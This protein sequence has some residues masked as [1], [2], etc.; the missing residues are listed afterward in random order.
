[1]VRALSSTM[2]HQYA[3]CLNAAAFGRTCDTDARDSDI[4]VAVDAANASLDA[5]CSAASYNEIGFA[6]E[7][8]SIR[9]GLVAQVIASARQLIRNTYVADYPDK[10]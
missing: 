5:A 9:D 1:M 6:G 10:P 3:S 4:A 2:F 8:A 7:Q